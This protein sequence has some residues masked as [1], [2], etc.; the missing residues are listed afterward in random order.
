MLSEMLKAFRE[1]EEPMDLNEL[2]RRLG[3]ERGVLE[4][5]LELLVNQGKLKEISPGSEDCN[6]CSSRLSCARL[7]TGNI[8]GK[9]YEL[10]DSS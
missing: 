7:Q 3:V 4:G 10:T 2:S 9:V 6:H 1:A 5:M 8:M